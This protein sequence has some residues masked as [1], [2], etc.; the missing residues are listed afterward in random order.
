MNPIHL[1]APTID[2]AVPAL[3]HILDVERL[4]NW[5]Y[6]HGQ[7]LVRRPYLRYKPDTSC[8]AAVE[9]EAGRAFLY[10]VAETARPKL[11]K[12]VAKA[13]P[14]SILAV[15]HRLRMVLAT[16]AADRDLPALRDLPRA[17]SRLGLDRGP[18]R[19]TEHPAGLSVLVHKPQ[20]RLVGL[21]PGRTG[22]SADVGRWGDVVLRAYRR[23]HV[24]AALDRHLR[25][26]RAQGVRTARVL[27]T[28][29]HYGLLAVEH[30]PGQPLDALVSAGTATPAVLRATGHALAQLHASEQDSVAVASSPARQVTV[31]LPAQETADLVGR[32]CPRLAERAASVLQHLTATA[33]VGNDEV[34]CHGDFSADQVIVD[35]QGRAGLIDWDRA[36][37]NDPA[38]D[39]AAAQAAGLAGTHLSD[40]LEGY[41]LLRPLPSNLGW[42]LAQAQLMRV[43]DPF[44]SGLEGWPEQVEANLA[45]VEVTLDRVRE[46]RV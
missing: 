20:R 41:R 27:G 22:A 37:F 25:A 5:L 42:H 31:S 3:D 23:G 4:G 36:G 26:G 46:S 16:V 2:A 17:I 44:R 19:P 40:L 7:V 12:V 24:T 38:T 13:P 6:A 18:D 32:I 34:L 11:D 29:R 35:A 43:A 10:G 15:D 45:S 33:P 9:L 14:G 8:V 28:S 21:L 1:T 30:L 39:L